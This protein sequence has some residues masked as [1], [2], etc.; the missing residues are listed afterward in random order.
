MDKPMRFV[1]LDVLDEVVV[2]S[3][4]YSSEVVH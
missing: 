4:S 2:K 3:R 1:A